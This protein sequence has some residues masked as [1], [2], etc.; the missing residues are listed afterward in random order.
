MSRRGRQILGSLHPAG[1]AAGYVLLSFANLPTPASGLWRPLAVAMIGALLLSL[2]LG[3][4]TRNRALGALLATAI[5][6][7]LSATWLILAVAAVAVLWYGLV[8][9]LRRFRNAAPL[10][11]PGTD[12]ANRLVGVFGAMFAIV[13]VV[14]AAPAA[15]HSLQFS[16]PDAES[17]ATEGTRPSIFIILLDGYPGDDVLSAYLDVDNSAFSASLRDSGFDI[18]TESRSNYTATW[19]T[20]ASMLNGRYLDEIDSLNPYP[21]DQ[22][23]QYASLMQAI[24]EGTALADLRARGYRI[25][26][27]PSP[28]EAATINTADQVLSGGQLTFFELSLLQHSPLLGAALAIAPDFLLDQQRLR[29]EHSLE[30]T[31]EVAAETHDDPVFMLTHIL[32]P[33]PPI[34]FDAR[35][36]LAELPDCFPVSCTL[37]EMHDASQWSG[38]SAQIEH[39]NQLALETVRRVIAADPGAVVVMMSDHGSRPPGAPEEVLLQNLLAVRSPEHPEL[40]ASN[41]HLVDLLATIF[42]AYFGTES[43]RHEYRGWISLAEFPLEMS[44]TNP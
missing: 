44:E 25:I 28:F 15:L 13:T 16:I 19:A 39:L 36:G 22:A 32:N 26:T 34:V 43:P 21:T 33:H 5:V 3:T 10:R 8:W 9:A 2:L 12:A 38:F 24:N 42:D 20:L 17:V 41:T 27:A 6:L 35:S 4:I 7:A 11:W 40:L 23:E 14:S 37:W 29:I 30:V 31:A 1:F 18:A